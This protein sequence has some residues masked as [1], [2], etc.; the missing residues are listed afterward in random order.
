MKDVVS[1][2]LHSEYGSVY[3]N[4]KLFKKLIEIGCFVSLVIDISINGFSEIILEV[5]T[6]DLLSFIFSLSIE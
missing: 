6:E 5:V 1:N 4:V 3:E 2:F